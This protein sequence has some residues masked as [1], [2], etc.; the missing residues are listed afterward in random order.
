MRM[1]EPLDFR[2]LDL[3]SQANTPGNGSARRSPG[4]VLVYDLRRTSNSAKPFYDALAAFT[5]EVVAHAAQ[6]ASPAIEEYRR[7]LVNHLR[8]PHRTSDEYAVE[9]LTLGMALRLYGDAA[10]E[11]PRWVVDLAQELVFRRRRS[12]GAKPLLDFVRAGLFQLFMARGL[13]T[14]SAASMPANPVPLDWSQRYGFA[15]LPRVIDWM[16]ATGEFHHECLRL[17]NWLSYLRT[18]PPLEAEGWIDTALSLYDWFQ[19][20]AEAALGEYT[21]SVRNFLDTTWSDRFWREDQVFCGRR[22]AEYHLAMV[23]SEIMN[24]AMRDE[25]HAKSRKV[26]LVPSCMRGKNADTCPAQVSGPDIS[27]A[28]CD[29]DC[30]VHRISRTMRAEGVET[31]IVPHSSGFSK[32]LER[33]QHEPDTGVAAVACLPNILA[34][35]Y[36]MRARGIASQCVPLDYPGC[37]KHWTDDGIPTTL[38]EDRLIQLVTTHPSQP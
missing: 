9:L 17:V 1:N 23:A 3:L 20:H 11:T 33:W 10:A 35:G 13:Q 34:G 24:A 7:Y 6:R 2:S 22:P 12:P 4:P 14:A 25:F 36:E 8:E 30:T 21:T 28:A 16:E 18:V 29:P 37:R 5:R 38:N 15:A 19:G 31:Y 26:L 32:S 27:C